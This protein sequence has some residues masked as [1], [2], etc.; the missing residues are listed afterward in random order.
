M[1]QVPQDKAF[2]VIFNKKISSDMKNKINMEIINGTTGKRVAFKIG[3]VE[4][5][6]VV[7]V[8]QEKLEKGKTYYIKVNDTIKPVTVKN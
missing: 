4:D 7:I 3:S 5:N 8:P 1:Q 6:K 2:T